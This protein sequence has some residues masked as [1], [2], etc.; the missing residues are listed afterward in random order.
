M[1]KKIYQTKSEIIYEALKENIITGKYKP[2]QRLIL[3]EIARDFGTSEIPVREALRLLISEGLLK[4]VPHVGAAV[5]DLN[6]EELE[7]IYVVRTVLEGLATRLASRN[8]SEKE[9]ELLKKNNNRMEKAVASQEYGKIISLNREFHR[10][11]YAACKNRYLYKSIFEFWDLSY[12]IP[13]VFALIPGIAPLSLSE[14]RDI[15]KALK[16]G[17]GRRAEELISNHKENLLSALRDYCKDRTSPSSQTAGV[18][19]D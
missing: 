5:T 16:D 8:I 1:R 10:I 3:S 15:L 17:D 11:I 2:K 13:G 19:L 6:I 18:G 9:L 14:H 7:E 12:R 4:N